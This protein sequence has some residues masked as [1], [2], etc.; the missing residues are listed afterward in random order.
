MYN[1]LPQTYTQNPQIHFQIWPWP[2]FSRS[3]WPFKLQNIATLK[4]SE[5]LC[6]FML[7]TS[8]FNYSCLIIYALDTCHSFS[9][10]LKSWFMKKYQIIWLKNDQKISKISIF[11]REALPLESYNNKMTLYNSYISFQKMLLFVTYDSGSRSNQ[12][13]NMSK[14]WNFVIFTILR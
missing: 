6:I 13:S 9:N 2:H 1:Q 7:R 8:I 12:R 10:I 14:M 3:F 5:N 4:K 11:D